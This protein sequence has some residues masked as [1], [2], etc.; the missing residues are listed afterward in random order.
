MI[1]FKLINKDNPEKLM[2]CY[3]KAYSW[4]KEKICFLGKEEKL[5]NLIKCDNYI[6][7]EGDSIIGF[8]SNGSIEN[9]IETYIVVRDKFKPKVEIPLKEIAELC[10]IICPNYRGFGYG[11]K[12]LEA[13]LE[14]TKL[15]YSSAIAYILLENKVSLN[16]YKSFDFKYRCTHQGEN[17]YEK[18]FTK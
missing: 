7:L 9:N 18:V 14:V 13:L 10:T 8:A 17:Y 6:M 4:D 1:N 3:R 5:C 2:Y 11:T 15:K 16:L 12:L